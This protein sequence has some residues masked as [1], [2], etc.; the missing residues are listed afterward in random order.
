MQITEDLCVRFDAK[1]GLSNSNTVE[2]L[3]RLE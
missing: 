1:R 3:E 2:E